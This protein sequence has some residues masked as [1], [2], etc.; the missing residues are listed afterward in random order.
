M[1]IQTF[2]TVL[3]FVGQQPPTQTPVPAVADVISDLTA[4][5]DAD[6]ITLDWTNNDTYDDVVI[7]R[8]ST[9]DF[10]DLA[11][12][13]GALETYDDDTA[14]TDVEYTYRVSGLV[15]DDL[16][17]SY[18]NEASDT[19][20]LSPFSASIDGSET[21]YLSKSSPTGIDNTQADV[22]I[23]GCWVN[24]TN[25][26]NNSFVYG[27]VSSALGFSLATDGSGSVEFSAQLDVTIGLVSQTPSTLT[28]SQKAFVI[29]WID[30]STTSLNLS[31]DGGAT[32]TEAY[33]TEFDSFS[34][35]YSTLAVGNDLGNNVILNGLIDE[36]FV[37][38]NPA[39]LA[40]A[41]T[42]L[43]GAVYNSGSGLKYSDLSAGQ[44][45]TLGLVSWW[46]LDEGTAEVRADLHGS[47]DLAVTG[48][49]TQATA[50][51][52]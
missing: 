1:D 29:A 52:S 43:K 23:V 22:L 46:G 33:A 42:L 38:K 11:T 49:V 50:I 25:K 31:V 3:G 5:A 27:D 6:S 19:V 47:N 18:S 28:N 34:N 7:Q 12:I 37:C 2:L 17:R 36:V 35:A 40:A 20:E 16:R 21:C 9:G 24:P 13:D 10:E 45:T 51:V 4:T 14:E 44:K 32:I 30:P 26:I 39:D 15:D 8:K 41:I 48:T